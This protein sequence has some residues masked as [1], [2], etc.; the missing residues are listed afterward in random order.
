M[1]FATR[2][3]PTA[4]TALVRAIAAKTKPASRARR[5]SRND[6]TSS[7]TIGR[8]KTAAELTRNITVMRKQHRRDA[9]D[10]EVLDV[11]DA[12]GGPSAGRTNVFLDEEEAGDKRD[13]VHEAAEREGG[14]EA[15]DVGHHSADDGT[16]RSA[17]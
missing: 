13:D 14:A 1:R 9:H 8:T 15:D 4:A 5:R 6:S 12:V 3:T 17:T 16:E 2:S 11:G 7:G 10:G